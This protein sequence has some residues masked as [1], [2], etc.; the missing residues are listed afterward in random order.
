LTPARHGRGAVH[1]RADQPG[2]VS[3]YPLT[4]AQARQPGN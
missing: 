1:R 4:P 2:L 3:A